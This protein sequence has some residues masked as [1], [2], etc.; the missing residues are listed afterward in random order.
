MKVYKETQY[1]KA[2]EIHNGRCVNC[3]KRACQI[4]HRIPQRKHLI[5]RYGFKVINHN[6]NLYPACGLRCNA[7]LQ[8]RP[9]EWDG[10]AE[11]IKIKIEK[12]NQS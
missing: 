8:A 12:E 6:F 1:R 3:G 5:K 7:I 2:Y 11:K 9:W 4:A 10:I